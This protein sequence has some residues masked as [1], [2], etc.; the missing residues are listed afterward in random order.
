MVHHERISQ[1]LQRGKLNLLS[2]EEVKDRNQEAI[3]ESVR[4]QVLCDLTAFVCVGNKLA[5]DKYQ[6]FVMKKVTT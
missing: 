4:Q 3:D 1:L 2:K 5:D 6:E